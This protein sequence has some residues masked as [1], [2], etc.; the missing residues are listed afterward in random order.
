MAN[1]K[2]SL[3]RLDG[4]VEVTAKFPMAN[5]G[6]AD[7]YPGIWTGDAIFGRNVAVVIKVF[8]KA[9]KKASING[10]FSPLPGRS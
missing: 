7:I 3:K 4:H 6:Y 8:R 5:G 2:A 10:S 9:N 1:M